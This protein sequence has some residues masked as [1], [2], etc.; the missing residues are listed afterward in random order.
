MGD[1]EMAVFGEAAQYL[2]KSD[3]ERL[4]AQTRPFDAKNSCFIDDQKEL[5][6]KALIISKEE[7]K[8]TV[9]TGNAQVRMTIYLIN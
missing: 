5:Y 2:R 7:G 9:K 4:E 8:V 6:V 1:S 3:L